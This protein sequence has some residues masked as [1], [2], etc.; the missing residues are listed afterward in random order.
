MAKQLKARGCERAQNQ[1]HASL[2][3]TRRNLR[4]SY[5]K[6]T[7]KILIKTNQISLFVSYWPVCEYQQDKKGNGEAKV[8]RTCPSQ[9]AKV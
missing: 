9:V 6:P 1:R 3:V 8:F 4:I 2:R 5:A 7:S